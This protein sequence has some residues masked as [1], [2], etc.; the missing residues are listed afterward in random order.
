MYIFSNTFYWCYKHL[1]LHWAFYGVLWS[2]PFF[3][4]TSCSF[5]FSLFFF[6]NFF[7]L[8]FKTVTLLSHLFLHLPFLLFFSPTVN[9]NVDKSYHLP[10]NH[11]STLCFFS[12]FFSLNIFMFCFHLFDSPLCT[13]FSYFPVWVVYLVSF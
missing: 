8:I 10:L 1:P 5:H 4:F 13:C 6:Y 3:P 2:F 12:F 9:L 11:I 7:N